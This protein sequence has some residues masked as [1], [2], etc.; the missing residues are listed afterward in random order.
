VR[1]VAEGGEV[2]P[3]TRNPNPET[4]NPK[5]EVG[6]RGGGG[7]DF[8]RHALER[9]AAAILWYVPEQLLHRN[10]QR[11]RG[12]LVF[13]AHR[14]WYHSTLGLRVIKKREKNSF[15]KQGRWHAVLDCGRFCALRGPVEKVCG[16]SFEPQGQ[17]L[18]LTVLKCRIFSTVEALCT[19]LCGAVTHALTLSLS[20]SLS[21]CLSLSFSHSLARSLSLSLAL[22]QV[23]LS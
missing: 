20:L 13:E 7:V 9:P 8:V 17:N 19:W 23:V 21:L 14:L 2:K 4:R 1:Q 5:P 3:E 12:G 11:F 22:T 18:A 15:Q 6:G 16:I 10:V